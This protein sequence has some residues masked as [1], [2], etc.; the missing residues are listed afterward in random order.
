MHRIQEIQALLLKLKDAVD[1]DT[2]RRESFTE[3]FNKLYSVLK[4]IF[5]DATDAKIRLTNHQAV[6]FGSIIGSINR[7][8][9][10]QRLVDVLEAHK[11]HV[12]KA[13]C[14][15]HKGAQPDL[16]NVRKLF[17]TYGVAPVSAPALIAD[18]T[19]IAKATVCKA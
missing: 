15:L 17:A 19:T 7:V 14:E 13:K 9:I 2:S 12:N 6:E 10:K 8:D 16:S 1:A 11:I 3:E 18:D 4:G 5:N